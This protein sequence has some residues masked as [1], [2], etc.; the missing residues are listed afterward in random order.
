VGGFDTSYN[1]ERDAFIVK[2]TNTDVTP[3]KIDE[4]SFIY[5]TSPNKLRLKF[6]ENVSPSLTIGDLNVNAVLGGAPV[7]VTNY[8]YDSAT[9][10]ATFELPTPLADGNY[11]ATLP[12]TSVTDTAGHPL[13]AD[14]TF[15]FFVLAGDADHD[16]DVDVNDLGILATNWQQSPR[17]FSQ[18]DFDYSGT[19]DVND[20]GILATRWQQNLAPPSAPVAVAPRKAGSIKRMATEVL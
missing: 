15:D 7:S 14:Y 18:G 5:D 9:N 3:P 12:A 13:P 16:R 11:R 4:A 8:T 17:T 19:V 10:T 20:L 6:S 1:P 2:I